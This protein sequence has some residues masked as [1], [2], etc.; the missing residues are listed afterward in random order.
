MAWVGRNLKDHAVPIPLLR[1]VTPFSRA[2]CSDHPPT[3][4]YHFSTDLSRDNNF[5][6]SGNSNLIDLV[7]TLVQ[8]CDVLN[9]DFY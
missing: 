4:L 1:A 2:G 9:Y 6:N 8:I 3:V 7:G 5:R